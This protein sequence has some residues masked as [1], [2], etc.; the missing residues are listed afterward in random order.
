MGG[1]GVWALGI[2]HPEQF[3]ALAPVGSWYVAPKNMC[4][5]RDVPVWDF[6]GEADMIV[7]PTFAKNIVDVLKR[8]GGN[9][10]LT[11]FPGEGH[12]QSSSHAYGMDKL[13]QWFLVQEK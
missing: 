9:V 5:L 8:C 7:P 6:Q 2:A 12:E 10:R 3:A 13:Y 11:L 4:V 1:D